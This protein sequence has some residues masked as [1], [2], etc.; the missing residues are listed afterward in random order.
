MVRWIGFRF[1]VSGLS[2]QQGCACHYPRMPAPETRRI[3]EPLVSGQAAE[4]RVLDALHFPKNTA[5]WR[6]SPDQV[7]SAVFRDIVGAPRYTATG[8]AR[9]TV[10]D[11]TVDGLAEIKSGRSELDST[12]QLRLQT[13]RSLIERRPLTIYTNRPIP[14]LFR[15]WLDPKGV[16]LKPLPEPEP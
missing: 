4:A 16:R 12:Y 9:G 6:P 7:R 15:D 3:P 1:Q 10:I 13:Y 5:V 8:L 2:L 14:S 11:S